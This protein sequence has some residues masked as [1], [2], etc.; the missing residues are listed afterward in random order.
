MFA[1]GN[2]SFENGMKF[3]CKTD[4]PYDLTVNYKIEKGGKLAIHIP[5][6]SKTFSIKINGKQLFN[7]ACRFLIWSGYKVYNFLKL[8]VYPVHINIVFCVVFP[9]FLKVCRKIQFFISYL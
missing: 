6:W 7:S 9:H 3:S 4:Y 2:V 5:S 8:V 1:G